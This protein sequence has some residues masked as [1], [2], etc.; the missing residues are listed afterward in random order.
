MS[1]NDLCRGITVI[2]SDVDGVMTDGGIIFDNQGI[3]VKRFHV[4]DGQGIKLWQRAG[5]K[6]G[7]ITSRNSHIVKLRSTELGIDVVRQ[8]FAEKL[9]AA[10][11]VIADLGVPASAVCY[12]G[13]DLPDVPVMRSVGLGIAVADAASEVQA[14]AGYVTQHPGG[15][16]AVREAVEMI[17]KA[18]GRWEE[19]IRRFVA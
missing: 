13:D 6:F 3:E 2:L 8:G 19:V 11:E 5:G 7:I 1:L 4:R 18:Q 16:G 10:R 9:P 15:H 12:I 14:A 17:L